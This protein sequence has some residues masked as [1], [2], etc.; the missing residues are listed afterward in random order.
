MAKSLK[1]ATTTVDVSAATAPSSGQVLTATGST[2]ATWQTPSGATDGWVTSPDTW[3][4]ASANSFTISGVDRTTTFTKGTRV[5]CTNNSTTFYGVVASSSFSTNTTVTL[6]ANSDYSLANSAITNPFYSY[7]ANPQ[8]YPGWFNYTPTY[9]GFSANPTT[10]SSRFNI[11]GTRCLIQH[12]ES[13]AG[14]SNA[15]GFTFSL[16]VNSSSTSGGNWSSSAQV[17]DS[18]TIQTNSGLIQ[19]GTTS[20]VAN[21]YKSWNA[22]SWTS[23]GSKACQFGQIEYEF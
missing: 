20:A 23:S 19:F 22:T 7:Q 5:K 13:V 17:Q 10:G 3:I 12:S 15:T 18:G 2:A 1:S 21:V 11:I 16:P 8:G 4:Y 9:T 14:T 6:V